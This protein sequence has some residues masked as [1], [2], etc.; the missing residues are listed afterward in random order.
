MVVAGRQAVARWAV[1]GRLRDGR[2][3]EAEVVGMVV[4]VVVVV[5]DDR[6]DYHGT[7]GLSSPARWY[8]CAPTETKL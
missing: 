4:H 7:V 1:G 6:D 5:G 2:A 3:E 8:T